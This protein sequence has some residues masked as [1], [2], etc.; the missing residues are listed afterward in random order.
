ME[1]KHRFFD[2]NA[3]LG[4]FL[5][6]LGLL[7]LAKHFGW[8]PVQISDIIFSFPTLLIAIGIFTLGHKKNNSFSFILIAVGIFLLI[9]RATGFDFHHIFWPSMLVIIGLLILVRKKKE[10][11]WCMEEKTELSADQIDEVNVFGGS[12]RKITSKNFR[13]GKITSVFG[14]CSLDLTDCE[15]S[16]GKN[17]L[18]VA[19]I[20][21]GTKLLIPTD[22]KIHVEVTSIFGGFADKRRTFTP[23]AGAAQKELYI[24]GVVIFGGG[25][26]KNF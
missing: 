4:I 13:G 21:G 14:G 20:F 22:W 24:T 5:I 9:H 16:E 18:D 3:L 19:N 2:K 1:T 15:L 6:G 11:E 7:F 26:I 17:V 8:I 23:V 25:E 10:P 12:E